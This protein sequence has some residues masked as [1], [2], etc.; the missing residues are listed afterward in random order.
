MI[1]TEIVVILKWLKE[2]KLAAALKFVFFLVNFKYYQKKHVLS[3]KENYVFE[4]ELPSKF[5]IRKSIS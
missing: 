2:V 3:K 1:Q 4:F 5:C